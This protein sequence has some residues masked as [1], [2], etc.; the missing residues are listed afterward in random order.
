M[1]AAGTPLLHLLDRRSAE[2]GLPRLAMGSAFSP[3]QGPLKVP[4]KRRPPLS[5]FPGVQRRMAPGA[6]RQHEV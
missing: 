4:P 5:L 6:A 2:R 3:S 1:S